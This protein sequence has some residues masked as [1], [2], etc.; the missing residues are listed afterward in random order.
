[1]HIQ[2]LISGFSFPRLIALPKLKDS[3]LPFCLPLDEREE[4]DSCFSQEH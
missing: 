4:K 2:V 1:M 3:V